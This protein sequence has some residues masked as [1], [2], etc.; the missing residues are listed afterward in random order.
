MNIGQYLANV[1]YALIG[2]TPPAGNVAS[3]RL[4]VENHNGILEGPYSTL[5]L[6]GRIPGKPPVELDVVEMVGF[7]GTKGLDP[8]Y[9]DTRSEPTRFGSRVYNHNGC[10]IVVNEA[11]SYSRIHGPEARVSAVFDEMVASGV[12]IRRPGVLA[13]TIA[14]E[15]TSLEGRI[16]K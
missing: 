10:A 7:F 5:Q 11:H 2:K 3:A 4:G 8:V 13:I 9:H 6:E 1:G 15:G 12:N 14:R 16:N